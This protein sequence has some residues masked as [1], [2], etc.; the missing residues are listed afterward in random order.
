M[1]PA[2][3][4]FNVGGAE[5]SKDLRP[6]NCRVAKTNAI[7]FSVVAGPVLE[8]TKSSQRGPTRGQ[9]AAW[10]L[11]GKRHAMKDAPAGLKVC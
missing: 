11:K 8:S 2:S 1:C 4:V 7:W 6:W 9:H 5:N 3:N 10:W